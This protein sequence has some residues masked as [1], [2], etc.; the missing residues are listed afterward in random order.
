M[1]EIYSVEPGVISE[2]YILKAMSL[3]DIF[4]EILKHSTYFNNKTLNSFSSFWGKND[5]KFLSSNKS[6]NKRIKNTNGSYVRYWN[7]Y[8]LDN[9]YQG[10]VK[11][12][13]SDILTDS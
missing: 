6:V 7:L 10:N 8:V 12:V 13:C 3:S 2:T 9:K 5:L 11:V 1:N 4:A